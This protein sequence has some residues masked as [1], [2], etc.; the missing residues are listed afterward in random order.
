MTRR[1]VR[2][3]GIRLP[4][5]HRWSVYASTLV[6]A[7]TGLA[8]FIRNDLMQVEPDEPQHWLLVIHGVVASLALVAFG[9]MLPV[10]VRLAWRSA[11]NRTSG[12][13]LFTVL[14]ILGI[15]GW[16]LY[17]GGE[18]L[19]AWGRWIHIIIGIAG[20]IALPLHVLLGRRKRHRH[21]HHG[22]D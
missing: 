2:G 5:P 22:K 12:G 20:I 14:A 6:V 13:T 19:R 3:P 17:Y 18:D 9:S 8:W 1:P 16:L 15:T 10:H 21:D 7:L 11:R 4:M